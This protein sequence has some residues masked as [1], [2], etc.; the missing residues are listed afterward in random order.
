VPVVCQAMDWR[1]LLF[2]SFVGVA[3]TAGGCGARLPNPMTA[4]DVARLDSGKALV[5]YLAEPDARPAVCDARAPGP[6]LTHFDAPVATT[7]VEGLTAGQIPPP[8]WRQC[9]DGVLAS[10]PLAGRAL[11]DATWPAYRD[12]IVDGALEASAPMQAQVATLQD[13]YIQRPTGVDG[14][15]NV[16]GPVA[17]DV[18]RKLFAR[19]LGPVASRFAT[20]LLDVVDLEQGRYGG[21]PV[22]GALLD[23]LAAR[24]DE[25][26]LRLFA[27]RL[28]SEALRGEARRSVVR[29]A[30]AASPF[31]EVR[32]DAAAVEARVLAQGVNRVSLATHP[33]TSAAV[34]V[35]KMGMRGLAV[36]QDVMRQVATFV[37]D[38]SSPRASA[39]PD[40]PLG[41]ALT[42]D[43]SGI[44]RPITLCRPARALDPSP[45]VAAEDVKI[46]SPLASIDGFGV[47]HFIDHVGAYNAAALSR[48][49]HFI[50]LPISIGGQR[51]A[52]LD[53]P[54]RFERPDALVLSGTIGVGP[55]L[56]VAVDHT[57]A[58]RYAFVVMGNGRE[59]HAV[60][61]ARDLPGF[62]VVS[63]GAIGAS[64]ADGRSGWD[65]SRG[66]D[67]SSASCPGSSGSDGTRGGDGTN[68]TDG[69]DGGPGGN[70]G[71]VR[72]AVDCGARACAPADLA[73][74][75][76]IIAS[77]GGPGGS[78][79][80]GGPGGRGG[81][82]GRGGSSTICT[83][84]NGV[85]TS[86]SGGMDGLSGSDGWSGH[87]GHDGSPGQP[88]RVRFVV[89]A[90][91]APVSTL[92]APS[93]A[94]RA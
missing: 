50:A 34:A 17:D 81:R 1:A 87:D 24:H 49:D 68:G 76:R 48:P 29:L 59:W 58:T 61:E 23:D 15:P 22:D 16:V 45:C 88:G 62:R 77:E 92:C 14:Q 11:I 60:V 36:R 28:P 38:G 75:K 30:I 6:H 83:D 20:A 31:P 26:L 70:G 82:G 63:R 8:V 3:G 84:D 41:S 67:G 21:R 86:V 71:D 4:A 53:W 35:Q 39:P 54:L 5:A 12:L 51:L 55:A 72:V 65:G 10:S 37:R 85:S 52:S 19:P 56:D 27:D 91:A 13:L 40:L 94:I 93:G 43:V 74:L 57:D 42:V 25:A 69:E 18:R 7:F 73:V 9:A 90:V 46:D 64:G 2:A 47:L 80:G 66:M 78:G 32:D 44:S 89:P 79:G 33:P